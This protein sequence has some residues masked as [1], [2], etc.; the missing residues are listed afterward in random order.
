MG[1]MEP[2]GR[3]SVRSG[4]SVGHCKRLNTVAAKEGLSKMKRNHI[5][6]AQNVA[7]KGVVSGE[8]FLLLFFLVAFVDKVF[9]LLL[10]RDAHFVQNTHIHRR[11]QGAKR[12]RQILA[13]R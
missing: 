1:R 8:R 4:F 3:L 7:G 11:I 10:A 13:V 12:G 6:F 5:H 2:L 9:M